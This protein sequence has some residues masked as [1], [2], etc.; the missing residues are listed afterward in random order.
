MLFSRG[1]RPLRRH[2]CGSVARTAATRELFPSSLSQLEKRFSS[3]GELLLEQQRKTALRLANKAEW[4]IAHRFTAQ[5]SSKF[6][7]LIAVDD[8]KSASRIF[9][10]LLDG[11]E[12]VMD[13]LALSWRERCFSN[14]VESGAVDMDLA[15]S[16][17]R[18]ARQAEACRIAGD[19]DEALNSLFYAPCGSTNAEVLLCNTTRLTPLGSLH[20]V[21]V[22][23]Y[24]DSE[25]RGLQPMLCTFTA[26]A[27]GKGY[28]LFR[29]AFAALDPCVSKTTI[30]ELNPLRWK[31]HD[32]NCYV[33]GDAQVELL[34][35]EAPIT[36]SILFYLAPA[37]ITSAFILVI[38]ALDITHSEQNRAMRARE[39]A[40]MIHELED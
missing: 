33:N 19:P 22:V 21:A 3:S 30:E 18:F 23:R 26:S 11:K 17:T 28:A 8:G 24:S 4:L 9:E 35:V 34:G 16:L 37:V 32:I 12:H 14:L 1:L 6:R 20:Y 25:D 5:A 7:R 15:D 31:L 2:L 13:A 40:M 39:E 27:D 38:F 10:Q 29:W 36:N